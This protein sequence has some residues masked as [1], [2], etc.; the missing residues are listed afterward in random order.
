[1][2]D[3]KSQPQYVNMNTYRVEK[4]MRRNNFTT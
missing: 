2:E 3:E 1:M 4:S